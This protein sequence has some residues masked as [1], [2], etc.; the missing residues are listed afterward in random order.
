MTT[1]SIYLMSYSDRGEALAALR[2]LMPFRDDEL[3]GMLDRLPLILY[4]NL[5]E[6][7]YYPDVQSHIAD[8]R[9]SGCEIRIFIDPP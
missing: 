5:D 7:E 2:R 3:E 8:F 4:D 9:E 6:V 1:H